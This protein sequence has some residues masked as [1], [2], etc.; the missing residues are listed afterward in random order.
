MTIAFAAIDVETTLNGNEDIG[1]AHP[2]H[3]D[4]RVVAYGLYSVGV[5]HVTYDADQFDYAAQRIPN[6][7]TLCGHNFSFDLM[8]L[9]KEST[10]LKAKLQE[11]KI[12]DTQIAE[13]ILSGQR[14][15]FSSLDELSIK[16]GLPVKDD[17]IKKYFQAGLGS[18]KIPPEELTPYL[19]QDVINT[20]TIAELQYLRAVEAGQ[21]TLIETQ[22]EALH[23]TTEMQFN[24]LH[25]DTA[26]LDNYTVEVVEKYVEIKLNLEAVA[27]GHVDD[28]NSPKQWSQFFFGGKKKVRVKEEVGI[29]KNGNPKYK[30][31]EK[32]VAIKPFISYV[33]DPE[34][35]SAKTGQVSVDDTV[36]ND[37]LKHTFDAKAIAIINGLL[38]YRELSKQLSTYV[39]GLSKHII[40]DF[41]H[42]KLNHTATVTGRL[43]STNPNLQNISNNPIKQ[44]FNSR[45]TDGLIVEV[46][47]NQLE[48][49]AL[50][51]VTNDKQLIKD[52]SGGADIH[53]E[54][55]K[56]MFGRY[57]TK[58]E[59]KPF[60]SR[61]FQLIY[62]AGAKAISKQAGCTLDEAKK[63][64]D[65]FYSRYK[66]V[67]KWHTEF[68]AMV[69]RQATN[70]LNEDGFREKFRTYVHQTETG[71]KYC[72]SEYYNEDAWSTRMYNFSP[73]E[74]KNY[75][76]Q[77]LATGDIV[78]M[79][80]GVI[81]RRLKGRD[82]VKMVNTVH[83]SL[84]F[85]VMSD[86]SDE[87][88][89]EITAIL[90]CTHAYFE[91]I[92]KKPLALK[93]NAGASVGKNWFD[94]KEL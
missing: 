91:D 60:K 58:E 48:V 41:I 69:E 42:G 38:K 55:Y 77:G 16:Y 81:F 29:Y 13:Y 36:L 93:L 67:A 33:P 44:I 37:M 51:H 22:M 49:V 78:P 28:I 62:G 3:P 61:T 2:M 92:F 26:R 17:T 43:S 82:D 8:Y 54:L 10:A 57:P 46:D 12:W 25:I 56:D 83:D 15:K 73:T 27:A 66:E 40:G 70:D 11:H 79:M 52:I 64:V 87:F 7:V 53:S 80:L 47:F 71:R 21:L 45:Y 59:R 85:D 74:M 63:F 30:L 5:P 90:Q 35:V 18:D 88:I 84:M 94:M 20:K 76:V 6:N 23:A 24:G 72:F 32:T 50:A 65:V 68:A 34:K 9:F 4:N 1:L 31:V 39:Q 75:P 14:T 89:T 19:E 86:Y